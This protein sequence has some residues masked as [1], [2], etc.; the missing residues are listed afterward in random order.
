MA[1]RATPDC[2]LPRQDPAPIRRTGEEQDHW[3][4]VPRQ[5]CASAATR[6]PGDTRTRPNTRAAGKEREPRVV[7]PSGA[8]AICLL[9]CALAA[10]VLL[11]ACGHGDTQPT[12]TKADLVGTWEGPDGATMK[13]LADQRLIVS[14][15][16]LAPYFGPHNCESVSGSGTWQFLSPQGDSGISPT[17]YSKG[18][19][20]GLNFN[21]PIS[22]VCDA[23]FTTWEINPPVGL[24]LDLDPDSPCTGNPLTKQP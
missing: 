19:L 13:F 18:N 7:K 20:I 15:L 6:K 2:D 1:L 22:S 4:C 23:E 12:L 14:G 17:A 11:A 21:S 9:L 8:T 16:D 3:L 10:G 24:C 5:R